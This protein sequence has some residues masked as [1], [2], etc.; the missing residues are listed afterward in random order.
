ML[1]SQSLQIMPGS[2]VSELMPEATTAS[3][4]KIAVRQEGHVP[5][6]ASP[7]TAVL[8][9]LFAGDQ[10]GNLPVVASFLSDWS[11]NALVEMFGSERP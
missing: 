8:E 6:A 11:E 4:E 1:N 9:Q 10:R 3:A 5:M 7:D 2:P